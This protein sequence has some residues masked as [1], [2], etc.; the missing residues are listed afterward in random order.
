MTIGHNVA[1]T[2]FKSYVKGAHLNKAHILRRLMLQF[3]TYVNCIGVYI[4]CMKDSMNVNSYCM[5][6]YH[7]HNH[8]LNNN[9]F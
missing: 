7:Y 8:I 9:N 6:A 2:C 1:L 3:V 5:N 4:Y